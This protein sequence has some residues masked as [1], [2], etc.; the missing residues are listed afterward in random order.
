M[1][2]NKLPI[3]YAVKNNCLAEETNENYWK[4]QNFRFSRPPCCYDGGWLLSQPN[5]ASRL[6]W[7][8]IQS[9]S[10]KALVRTN[11]LVARETP[12]NHR[13][14]K[15]A[16]TCAVCL[17]ELKENIWAWTFCPLWREV[18]GKVRNFSL[19]RMDAFQKLEKI[20]EGTYGVVYKAK[21]KDSGRTVALKKIR[22]DTW[23]IFHSD[24]YGGVTLGIK[25]YFN[26][27]LCWILQGS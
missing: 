21:D 16:G 23:V 27:I 4:F 1:M 5:A 20:G 13:C 26:K 3:K 18:C 14:N 9:D 6:K 17:L 11:Q 25:K 10:R 2:C 22:L 15:Q 24:L 12:T 7:A 19:S 8:F